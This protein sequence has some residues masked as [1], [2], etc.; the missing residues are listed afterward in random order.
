MMADKKVQV[1]N[2][3]ADRGVT[4]DVAGDVGGDTVP[5]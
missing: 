2:V 1:P 4:G 3:R 5:V